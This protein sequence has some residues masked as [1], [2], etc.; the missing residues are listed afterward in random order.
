MDEK[1]NEI[2]KEY[3][4]IDMPKKGKKK[5]VITRAFI[6]AFLSPLYLIKSLQKESVGSRFHLA[7]SWLAL[8]LLGSKI[9]L[10]KLYRMIFAPMDSVRYFEFDYLWELLNNGKPIGKYL[11][12]SS[13]R[14]FSYRLLKE[15]MVSDLVLANPDKKDLDETIELY[16]GARLI[17]NVLFLNKNAKQLVEDRQK[18]DTIVSISVLEHIPHEYVEEN[19][20]A[21]WEMLSPG[22]RLLISLPCCKV[23]YDEYINI[24]EY[25]LYSVNDEGYVF[26]QTF[27]SQELI[28]SRI[29]KIFGE[30]IHEK[31]FGEIIH[32]TFVEDRRLKLTSNNYPFWSESLRVSNDYQQYDYIE[33]LPGLGVIAMEFRKK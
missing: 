16:Q 13:P 9:E 24:D 1:R 15:G 12:I 14:F 17:D 11:D 30:I 22:G 28:N 19:L 10:K 4:Y 5:Q 33:D 20:K 32:G 7:I 3:V 29:K 21:I 26:A 25:G 23:P 18:Y 8:S 6:G 2:K 27:Y 31:I